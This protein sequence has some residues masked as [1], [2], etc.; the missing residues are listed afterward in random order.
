MDVYVTAMV[1]VENLDFVHVIRNLA[2][3]L[4]KILN[5][6]DMMLQ[7]EVY[8]LIAAYVHPL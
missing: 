8:A 3:T 7:Q 6:L 1:L 2:A 5:A 4:V